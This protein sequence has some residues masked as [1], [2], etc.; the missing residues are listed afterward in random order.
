MR[1]R[2]DLFDDD[3]RWLD[4]GRTDVL[5]FRNGRGVSVTVMGAMPY[6]VPESWGSLNLTSTAVTQRILPPNSTAWLRPPE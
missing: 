1:A 5:A 3:F 2:R 4:T 6:P